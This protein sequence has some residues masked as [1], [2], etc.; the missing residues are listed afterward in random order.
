MK[1]D[2]ARGLIQKGCVKLSPMQP[3]TYAS[4]LKGPIYCDNRLILGHV[5][6]RDQVVRGFI[7][8][9]KTKSLEFDLIGGIATAG[10][11]HAAFIADRLNLPM[12]Y[13]R[14]KAKE[15]G[16]KNQIEGDYQA[17]Q[18]ILLVE[19]LVNQGSS[20]AEA[21]GGVLGA[22]LKSSQC[23]SIV[24]YQMAEAKKRL[25]EL[26]LTLYSLTDFEHLVEAASELKLIDSEGRKLLIEWHSDPK[27][28][29][30]LI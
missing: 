1:M 9:I 18:S 3:F 25:N 29:S 22:G 27:G 20:L 2:I 5:D 16:K 8:L 30:Q 15:H 24:D 13:I 4:G 23:L 7:E 17:N 12:V 10:I 19:D 6:F 11:P 14:P 28:W 21:M 26:S